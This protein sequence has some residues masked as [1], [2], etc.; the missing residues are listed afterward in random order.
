MVVERGKT[1]NKIEAKRILRQIDKLIR[2]MNVLKKIQL[3]PA[4]VPIITFE[5]MVSGCECDI[6]INNETGIR[7]THLLRAYSKAD[8]RVRPLVMAVK[9]WGKTRKI[10]DAK[11][12][13][14]SSYSLVLMVIHYLQCCEPPVLTSLRKHYPE[15]FTVDSDVDS[16]PHINTSDFVPPNTSTNKDSLGKLFAGFLEYYDRFRWDTDV[17]SVREGRVLSRE[18]S[19]VFREAKF[20]CIE[21]PFELCNTARTVY[22]LGNFNLIKREIQR[23]MQRLKHKPNSRLQ[24]IL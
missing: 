7:N 19:P 2:P 4:R 1:I 20:I 9:H 21:E 13:T 3:I 5:D 17:M 16:L 6:N 11:S 10:N 14:L 8:D 23:A 22:E 18:D 24:Y 15:H 12:G